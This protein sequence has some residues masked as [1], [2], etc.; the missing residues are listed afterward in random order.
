M[1]DN[2]K[3]EQLYIAAEEINYKEQI[4]QVLM[5]MA[6]KME[7]RLQEVESK[8]ESLDKQIATLVVGFGEQAVFMDALIAQM[9]FGTPEAQK[10]FHDTIAESRKRMLQ[11]M[12]EGSDAFLATSSPGLA[13]AVTE[14]AEQK[15]SD[16]SK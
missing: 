8:L 5:V 6:S 15:L 16:T 13:D 2:N 9:A 1:I 12:K 4:D 14:L 3:E 10:A 11:I 7:E